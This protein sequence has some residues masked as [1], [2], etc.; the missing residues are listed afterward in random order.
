ME[1]GE[2]KEKCNSDSL[3]LGYSL[4]QAK[5]AQE[6]LKIDSRFWELQL[7]LKLTE[8]IEPQVNLIPNV[9]T[10]AER[11]YMGPGGIEP[12]SSGD[13]ELCSPKP[14]I[15]STKLWAPRIEVEVHL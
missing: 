11:M 4:R 13:F 1:S 14:D 9:Y 6:V 12:P 5:W 7:A 8:V 10:F 3:L 2:R 15:L